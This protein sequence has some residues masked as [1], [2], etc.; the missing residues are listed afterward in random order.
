[1]REAS[2]AKPADEVH[3]VI[4]VAGRGLPLVVCASTLVF[5]FMV[6]FRAALGVTLPASVYLPLHILAEVLAVVVGFAIFVVHWHAAVAKRLSHQR[7]IFLGS[8]FLGVALLD[9]VHVLSFPGMPVFIEPGTTERGIY[10]WLAA[11][12]W[13]A[14]ALVLAAFIDQ[15][16]DHPLLRRGPLLL[17]NALPVALLLWLDTVTPASVQIFYVEGEGLTPLK[18][19][20]EYA[21]VALSLVAIV[22]YWRLFRQTRDRAFAMLIGAL[23]LTVLSELS[24]TLY[25]TAYDAFN[26]LG[27]VYKVVAY[28][29]IFDGLFVATL[30]RPYEQLDATM[31][32]L[33]ASNRELT[34][35]REHIEGELARTIASLA[36]TSQ[37]ERRAR[38]SAETLAGLAR[39]VA[40]HVRLPQVLETLVERTREIF[41]ADFAALATVEDSTGGTVWQAVA[42]NATEAFRSTVFPPGNGMA[43]R[44]IARNAPVIVERFG[45]AEDFPPAEFPILVAE[46]ARSVLAVPVSTGGVPFGAFIVG[47][48][49]DH[50]FSGEEVALA[51]GIAD[52]AAVALQNAR[53]Y[54]EINRWAAEQ[55]AVIS[56]IADGVI[57]YDSTGSVVR[58]NRAAMEMLGYTQEDLHK[59]VAERLA[60]IHLVDSQGRRLGPD[61]VPLAR[62]LRGE[63]VVGQ[64][65]LVRHPDGSE[66]RLSTSVAPVV[67]AQGRL[68]GAV[69]TLHDIT[70]LVELERRREEFVRI[71]AHDIRQP[72]TIIQ[73]Q[74]QLLRHALATGNHQRLESGV[75]AILTGARR[76][77]AMIRDLVESIRLEMGQVEMAKQ[78]VDLAGFVADMLE[79]MAGAYD[80]RRVRLEARDGPVAGSPLLVA[81]D[82]DRLERILGNLLSNALKYSD[83]ETPVRVTIDWRDGEAVVAVSDQGYGIAPED[84]PH[85]FARF[86]RPSGERQH[87]KESLGLGLYI[88][89]MLVEAHGGRVWA[90]SELGRGS[91]FTFTLPLSDPLSAPRAG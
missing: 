23:A 52:H 39:D 87:Q 11:R 46:R 79:R 30:L 89:K 48:R 61:D 35:L 44:A 13:A 56:S 70:A 24:F 16:A 78:P 5:L 15:E 7:A 25:S 21:V 17:L 18:V 80:A 83:P 31:C 58:A 1:M 34:R 43:G 86:H 8:A 60:K 33:A 20:L 77:N 75:N 81:A 32:E 45:E 3:R 65:M 53:L 59:P 68:V 49:H 84:L 85:L 91:T 27:H 28:Y 37:A 72:L 55:E 36:N 47:Y 82:P 19:A 26:L 29:L 74:A 88:T 67:D 4:D 50:H 63:T 57:V 41:G 64:E 69:A 9:T 51:G 12:L 6:A 40:A 71:V 38:E 2:P 62:A 66:S 42:G 73:G 54:E 76:M 90:Q 22:L 14:S 10:Y